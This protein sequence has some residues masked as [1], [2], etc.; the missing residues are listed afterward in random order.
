MKKFTRLV[1]V[2]IF[3]VMFSAVS[4]GGINMFNIRDKYEDILGYEEYTAYWDIRLHNNTDI[5]LSLYG[6][7][8]K[9]GNLKQRGDFGVNKYNHTVPPGKRNI[10]VSY[11]NRNS[12][13]MYDHQGIQVIPEFKIKPIMNDVG[14][15]DLAGYINISDV[16]EDLYYKNYTQVKTYMKFIDKRKLYTVVY[17][18]V[19]YTIL[20]E[21]TGDLRYIDITVNSNSSYI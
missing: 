4:Y 9:Y 12:V 11:W 18:D 13:Y 1:V 7:E 17:D 19:T 10:I 16:P 20:V 15:K 6:G 21:Y 2:L 3:P 14:Y 8:R 5:E